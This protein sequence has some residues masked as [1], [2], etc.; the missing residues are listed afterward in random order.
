LDEEH[1]GFHSRSILP[2]IAKN[3][4]SRA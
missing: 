3:G 2:H 1:R 4:Q